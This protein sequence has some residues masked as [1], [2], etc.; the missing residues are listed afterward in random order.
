MLPLML[1]LLALGALSVSCK[2]REYNGT[3]AQNSEKDATISPFNAYE[4]WLTGKGT[5]IFAYPAGYDGFDVDPKPDGVFTVDDELYYGGKN[6]DWKGK[7]TE[8]AT[9][10]DDVLTY[11]SKD[12][13][14]L[15]LKF[16]K[17]AEGNYVHADAVKYCKDK[18]LRL[19]HVQE[20]FDFCLAGTKEAE[21]ENKS[22]RC[23]KDDLWSVSLYGLYSRS[24]PQRAW[25]FNSKSVR[26]VGASRF[27][28][29]G[30]SMRCVGVP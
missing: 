10:E 23:E 29:I 11:P 15:S 4:L 6:G 9:V 18:G 24:S 27:N 14:K 30:L 2:S 22:N 20:L 8:G 7:T 16:S 19:P 25:I 1:G 17:K 3:V 13:R 26:V 21:G 5:P 12:G 28:F